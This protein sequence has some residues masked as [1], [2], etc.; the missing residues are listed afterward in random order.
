MSKVAVVISFT[1]A[2]VMIGFMYVLNA[3]S[4]FRSDS[5]STPTFTS[6]PKKSCPLNPVANV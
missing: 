2:A 4:K 1:P 6:G 5:M 3:S